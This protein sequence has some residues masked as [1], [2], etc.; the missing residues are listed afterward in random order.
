MSYYITILQD[1]IE[2][3]ETQELQ[4]PPYSEEMEVQEKIKVTYQYFLRARRLKQR[5]PFLIF[6]YFLGQLIEANDISKRKCKQIVTDHYYHIAVRTYY[7][8]EVKPAQIYV[9]KNTSIPMIRKLKQSE[10]KQLTLEL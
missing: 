8:F 6:A 5:I 1:L 2:E 3:E 10:F 4:A 9:T 7:I